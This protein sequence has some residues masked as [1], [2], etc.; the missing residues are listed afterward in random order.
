M[1]CFL[2]HAFVNGHIHIVLIHIVYIVLQGRESYNY[3]IGKEQCK[4]IEYLL[5]R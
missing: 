5:F 4:N 3:F 1:E 2:L